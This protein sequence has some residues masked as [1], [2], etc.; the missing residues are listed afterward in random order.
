[1]HFAAEQ[2]SKMAP[3]IFAAM[4]CVA[5]TDAPG[6]SMFRVGRDVVDGRIE[7]ELRDMWHTEYSCAMWWPVLEVTK[8]PLTMDELVEVVNPLDDHQE[9]IKRP[10]VL[11]HAPPLMFRNTSFKNRVLAYDL[12][13]VLYMTKADT[14]NTTRRWCVELPDAERCLHLWSSKLLESMKDEESA[15]TRAVLEAYIR[16]HGG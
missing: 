1:M 11:D 7:V 5:R 12:E 6:R 13:Q 15:H 3:K 10:A 2:V 14:I 9:L 8:I 16:R 4:T